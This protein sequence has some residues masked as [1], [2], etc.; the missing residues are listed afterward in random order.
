MA[1]R[2]CSQASDTDRQIYEAAMNNVNE[3]A[4]CLRTSRL[5]ASTAPP[6]RIDGIDGVIT[7]PLS[8]AHVAALAAL[9]VPNGKLLPT[10]FAFVQPTAWREIVQDELQQI[11]AYGL[12]DADLVLS[13]L[14]IDAVGTGATLMPLDMPPDVF[15]FM[16]L[17][18]PSAYD[19]GEM[20]FSYRYTT[21]TWTP[22]RCK[23]EVVTTFRDV[24][25]A[26]TPVTKGVR[27]ALVYR[28]GMVDYNEDGFPL[29]CDLSDGIDA[30]KRIADM[31]LHTFQRIA[32][33]IDDDELETFEDPA[34]FL[35]F[36]YLDGLD[37]SLVDTLLATELY[38]IAL[39]AFAKQSTD[40]DDED[41]YAYEP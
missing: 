28:L 3:E 22:D 10:S 30:F 38:D 12:M 24:V 5:E 8:S 11:A 41:D 27:M 40:D 19:G 21:E 31:P 34:D 16:I 23:L 1:Q 7:W 33:R 37:A 14:V 35:R 29:P 6:L 18:L 9:D 36:D 25:P 17:H 4:P 15:G 2:V 26:S 20:K 32:V 13:H 39:V